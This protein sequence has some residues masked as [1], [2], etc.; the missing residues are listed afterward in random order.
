[1]SHKLFYRIFTDHAAQHSFRFAIIPQLSPSRIDLSAATLR[2][3]FRCMLGV[4]GTPQMLPLSIF[5]SVGA[6]NA[7]VIKFLSGIIT[8][9]T[10]VDFYEVKEYCDKAIPARI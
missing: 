1:M 5:I 9:Y 6:C 4:K 3:A 7:G 10:R 2:P 8:R